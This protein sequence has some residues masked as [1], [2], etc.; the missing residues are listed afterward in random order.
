[1]NAY[2]VAGDTGEYSDHRAWYVRVFLDKERADALAKELND[3]CKAHNCLTDDD[4]NSDI[5]RY[6]EIK[7]H[8][9]ED[10]DFVVD[11]TGTRYSVCEV[12]YEASKE[13]NIKG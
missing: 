13:F 12:P 8:P 9:P 3:W 4:S 7:D 6:W 10:P 2:I 1:M 5:Q 11:Y